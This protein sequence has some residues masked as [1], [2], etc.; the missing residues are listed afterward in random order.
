[1]VLDQ[2]KLDITGSVFN[3]RSWGSYGKP[4]ETWPEWTHLSMSVWGMV[5][6]YGLCLFT[7]SQLFTWSSFFGYSPV[8]PGEDI[9][10]YIFRCLESF[11]RVL[12]AHLLSALWSEGRSPYQHTR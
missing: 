9:L 6:A 11:I 7:F 8:A 10:L 4:F 5:S 1:M 3:A 12:P 2:E